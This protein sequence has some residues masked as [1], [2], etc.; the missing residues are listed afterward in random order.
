M[1]YLVSIAAMLL[2]FSMLF[3]STLVQSNSIA[4]ERGSLSGD[5]PYHLSIT[6]ESRELWGPEGLLWK[7]AISQGRMGF[8]LCRGPLLMERSR[9]LVSSGMECCVKSKLVPFPTHTIMGRMGR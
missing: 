2:C 6:D 5:T 1:K 9:V 4:Q 8:E 7:E 3:A